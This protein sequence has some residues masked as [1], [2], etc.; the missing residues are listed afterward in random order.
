MIKEKTPTII[1]LQGLVLRVCGH[2]LKNRIEKRFNQVNQNQI[3]LL[4]HL[5]PHLL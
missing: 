1:K 4:L 5:V 2:K 3:K